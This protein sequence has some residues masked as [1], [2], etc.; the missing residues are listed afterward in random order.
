MKAA[1]YSRIM[2]EE[3]QGNVQIFFDELEKQKI[4][5]VIFQ[6]FFEQIKTTIRLPAN[7]SVFSLS[8][9]FDQ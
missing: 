6:P 3:Q 2:E 5:P 1:I 8:E 7:T 4:E 9:A